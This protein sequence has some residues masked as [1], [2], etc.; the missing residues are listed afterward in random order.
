MAMN[1][2][3][4]VIQH[5]MDHEEKEAQFYRELAGRAES[6]DVREA[7]MAHAR[8]EEEHRRHLE[9]IMANHRLPSGK[10]RYPDPDLKISDYAVVSTSA[11]GP[12]SYEEALLM[13]AKKE[14]MAER[15]Y[16]D[17][18]RKATDP[19]LRKVF[20]F[21]ADQESSHG[22]RLEQQYDDTL[23]EG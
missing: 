14:K 9:K 8:E 11:S 18:A 4:E 5:A 20:E 10:R 12:L 6:A 21:L 15:L 2:F 3:E 1:S 22:K 13:A 19:E 7:M 23:K 16:R 17:L